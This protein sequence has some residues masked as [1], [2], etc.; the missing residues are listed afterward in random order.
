VFLCGGCWLTLRNEFDDLEDKIQT[1]PGHPRV[2]PTGCTSCQCARWFDLG[3]HRD[4]FG[5]RIEL[6]GSET[7]AT[8]SWTARRR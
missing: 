7:P 1:D 4:L 3:P 8:R 2:C 6:R 5:T